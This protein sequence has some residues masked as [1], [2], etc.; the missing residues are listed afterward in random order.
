[1][2]YCIPRLLNLTVIRTCHE[3]KSLK[4]LRQSAKFK[5]RFIGTQS[6]YTRPSFNRGVL[7]IPYSSQSSLIVGPGVLPSITLLTSVHPYRRSLWVYINRRKFEV[8]RTYQKCAEAI[9][10]LH[11]NTLEFAIFLSKLI[12]FYF[13]II[14]SH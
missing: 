13:R 5:A 12:I 7:D 4:F 1:M 10:I 11:K 8:D 14:L 9:L 3:E 6:W 2:K